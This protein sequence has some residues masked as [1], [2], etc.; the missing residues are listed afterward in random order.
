[1]EGTC[2]KVAFPGGWASDITFLMKFCQFK[3]TDSPR[4]RLGISI[5]DDLVCDVAELARAVKSAGGAPP[6]WLLEANSTLAV[7]RGGK[8]AAQEIATLLDGGP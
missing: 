2:D 4:Q 5:S 6:V 1:M 7:I 3:T 8:S